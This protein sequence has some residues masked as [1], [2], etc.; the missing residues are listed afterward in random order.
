MD[1]VAKV[2][3]HLKREQWKTLIKECQASGMT[4]TAWCKQNDICEQTYYRN[5]KILREEICDS[6]PVSIPGPEKP[7]T[8]KKL[9]VQSPVANT[10]AAVIIH[11]PSASLEIQNGA[12]QQTVE[13]VLLALKNIC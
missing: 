8:F 11:L 1:R 9:E 13:A 10:Q 5:L 2:K 12:T 4:I 7:V 6:L 3:K